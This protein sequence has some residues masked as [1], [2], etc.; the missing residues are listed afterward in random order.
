M[1]SETKEI[2]SIVEFLSRKGDPRKYWK[3]YEGDPDYMAKFNLGPEHVPALIELACR[4]VDIDE[5]CWKDYDDSIFAPVHAWYALGQLRAVEAVEPLLA[6]QNRLDEGGDEWYLED[7]HVV[8][9]M[10][11]PPAIPALVAYLA[12]RNNFEFPRLSAANGLRKIG[13]Q[14]PHS[15]QEVVEVLTRQLAEY[16][17]DTYTL[18]GFL[19]SFLVDLQA[20]ESAEVI[21]RAFAAGIVDETIRGEWE[22]IREELGVEGLGLVPERPKPSR[23]PRPISFFGSPSF[24]SPEDRQRQREKKQKAKAKRKQQAKARKRNRKRR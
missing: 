7:F 22:D 12:D 9:G 18:N 16:E 1:M 6:M 21:E 23:Q 20:K 10:I 11:G 17:S 13:K 5:E 2:S 4:W 8:F 15:R 19:V 3:W 24:Y 14:H